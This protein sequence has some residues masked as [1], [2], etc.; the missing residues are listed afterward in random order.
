MKTVEPNGRFRD[1]R[2]SAEILAETE[3][4]ADNADT[5]EQTM[6]SRFMNNLAS[7]PKGAAISNLV[8]DQSSS[9]PGSID[10]TGLPAEAN[11]TSSYESAMMALAD[12]RDDLIS[13]FP[14]ISN[15]TS[16]Y[17]LF[18]QSIHKTEEGLRKLGMEVDRFNP[19]ASLSGLSANEEV[20]ANAKE[21]VAN[22]QK[23]YTIHKIADIRAEV[24]RG[25]PSVAIAIEGEDSGDKFRASGRI[26][27]VQD[28]SGNEAVDFVVKE[29]QC[30]LSVKALSLGKYVDVSD[31]FS[32]DFDVYPVEEPKVPAN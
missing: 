4:L 18:V 13:R 12:V 14:A 5:R 25:S 26:V 27:A 16:L 2:S 6:F 28:F 19:L 29:G 11:E 7:N 10:R 1:K 3:E 21:V 8:S 23:S 22:T 9:G 32:I 24:Y 31:R 17:N 30:A 20:L 15:D